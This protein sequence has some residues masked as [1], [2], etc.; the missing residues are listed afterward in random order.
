MDWP[1]CSG[2]GPGQVLLYVSGRGRVPT[3]FNGPYGE[4][5]DGSKMGAWCFS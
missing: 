1:T 4:C 5:V 2:H 3:K